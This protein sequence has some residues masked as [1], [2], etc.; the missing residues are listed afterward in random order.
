RAKTI[1]PTLI[2]VPPR[3]SG[4]SHRVCVGPTE[5]SIFLSF[6]PEKKARKRLSGDQKGRKPPSV[7]R[8]GCAV[9]ASS[10]RNQREYLPSEPKALKT[11]RR[12]SGEIAA[13][14]TNDVFSGTAIEKRVTRTSA[15]GRRK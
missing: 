13:E 14:P 6:P 11:R 8:S 4:S 9:R 15:G 1:T 10:G 7:P 2:Q 5:T 3:L 12:P